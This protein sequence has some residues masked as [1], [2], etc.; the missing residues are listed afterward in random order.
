MILKL[1]KKIKKIHRNRSPISKNDID[2]NKIVVSNKL[3]FIGY[4]DDKK[5]KPLCIFFPKL[6]AYRID[7]DE[8]EC[9][10]VIKKEENVFDIYMD[11]LEK[12][13]NI[14]KI[15]IMVNLYIVKNI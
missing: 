2:I 10:H 5:I 8:T 1:K 15:K 14:I 3:P 9:M 7:F 12:V 4:K 6:S 11:I 13:S